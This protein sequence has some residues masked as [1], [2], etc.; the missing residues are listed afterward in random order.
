MLNWLLAFL[1][2]AVAL[3]HL[4][5]ER[6]LWI[7]V[8]AALAIIPIAGWMGRA[9]EELAARTGEG[10]GGLLNATFG[11]AAELIIALAALRAGLHDVVKASLAGALVGNILLVL[12]D[13]MLVGGLAHRPEQHFNAAGARS[14]STMLTLATIALI[15]PAAFERVLG[16]GAAPVASLSVWISA[17]LLAVYALNLVFSLGTH[18]A[19]FT[20][21]HEE[22]EG[23]AQS[24]PWSGRRAGLVLGAATVA[25]AWMSEILVG[26][27]EPTAQTLGLSKAFVGVFVVAILGNA[28]E[29]ATAV[30]A[31]YKNRMDL[32]L[33]VAIG[34]SVQ[35][36]LFVAPF[37]VLLSYLVAPT[38]MDFAFSGGLVLTVLLSVLILGQVAADGRSDWLKGVQLLAVYVILGLAFYFA[39]VPARN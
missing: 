36:S 26:A 22:A 32:A 1:P 27:M 11:N 25:I 8:A 31:A 35:V 39:P 7:F 9:T 14:Q 3:E 23:A 15:L 17:V 30:R 21:S 18:R 19:L 38:P 37:L 16:E 4:A 24:A 34:A 10:V 6:S 28:A 5:P 2:I 29:H 13:A 20:G 12:G 33:S